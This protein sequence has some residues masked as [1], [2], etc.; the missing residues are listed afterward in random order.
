M[1]DIT[2]GMKGSAKK[3]PLRS[4]IACLRCRKSK[5]KCDNDHG[6]SPCDT[7]I[8][9]GKECIYPEATVPIPPKR[10]DPPAVKTEQAESN[11]KRLKK[12]EDASR[13]ESQYTPELYAEEVLSAHYLTE[14][15]WS[16]VFD[17]YRLHFSTELPFLHLATLKEK[18][19]SRF[20]A[21][22]ADMRQSD[23]RDP[24]ARQLDAKPE[25]TKQADAAHDTNVVLLGILT[26]TARFHPDLVAYV[27]G[28][29]NNISRMRMSQGKADPS[30]AAAASEYYAEALTRA[31]G[32]LRTSMTR[33]SVERV[34]AFLMLGLYEW[35]QVQP[36]TGG[37]GAWMYV[38]LAIRMAQALGLGFGDKAD[39]GKASTPP[40]EIMIE[41]EIKRRTMFSCFILDRMLACGKERVY[42]IRSE[43][44][45]IQLPCDDVAFDLSEHVRTGFLKTPPGERSVQSTSRESVL[46]L[47]VR[48]VDIWGEISKYSF[49]GGRL[50]E[51]DP[52]WD[53]NTTFFR[54]QHEL[55]RF[56][57]N[58]PSVFRWST[59]NYHRH[60]NHQGSSVYVSLHMLGSVC[61]IMLHREYI[62]FIPLRCE[63]PIGPLDAPTFPSGTRP[64]WWERSA[65]KVF[66]AARDVVAVIDI[67]R[68][69]LPMSALALFSIYIA[70][71]VGLYAFHFPHMDEKRHMLGREE[72]EPDHPDPTRH[73]PTGLTFKT[74]TKM[75]KWL[76]MAE[77]YAKYFKD[78]NKYYYTV[79]QDYEH[80]LLMER[81][82]GARGNGQFVGGG[83]E[84]WKVKV[85]KIT[86]NG[87]ILARIDKPGPN[88]ASEQS[89]ASSEEREPSV[90]P[91]SYNTSV[92]DRSDQQT[93]TPRST[94]AT[95]TSFTA[96]NSAHM[97]QQGHTSA[98][99]AV[100]G[101]ATAAGHGNAAGRGWGPQA[102]TQTQYEQL[103]GSPNQPSVITFEAPAAPVLR[104]YPGGDGVVSYVQL[105]QNMAWNLAPG[106]IETFSVGVAGPEGNYTVWLGQSM[107]GGQ[108]MVEGQLMEGEQAMSGEHGPYPRFTNEG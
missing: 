25:D 84:E 70:S 50:V 4:S 17:I 9:S 32:P 15:L 72:E 107:M 58:L 99:L 67:C 102:A 23:A 71:F 30:V 41:K 16:Q 108:S 87:M 95:P 98:G 54:L 43:D 53:P 65:E 39:R 11:R 103:L 46:S 83:L 55:E 79:K 24:D 94:L 45:Q 14:N 80:A 26:L 93:R 68:D 48:L 7:C 86:N 62:P 76:Q 51:K 33:A 21:R 29:Q 77:T 74:L 19:G 64:E 61:Q 69:K 100:E 82:S 35:S 42:T 10:P 18:M 85:D 104:G 89:R 38:G 6:R 52:P 44:L 36:R 57:D 105:H 3:G 75:S 40:P 1:M 2:D 97:A 66:S 27:A 34:Q 28:L 106:G 20:R 63:K 91:E 73:G 49:A 81:I 5:I 92:A 8:K 101:L 90:A 96:I 47:F 59:S 13:L 60:E 12:L 37:V 88:D 31:L 78:L 56:Y 22:Q